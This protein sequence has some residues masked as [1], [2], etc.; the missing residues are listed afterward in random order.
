M[1]KIIISALMATLLLSACSKDPS[2]DPYSTE[3]L[4]WNANDAIT[5]VE[6]DDPSKQ[7]HIE[8]LRVIAEAS[9]REDME[10]YL[11]IAEHLEKGEI[12]KAKKLYKELGGK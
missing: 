8:G 4:L 7:T 10:K 2:K 3:S 9:L 5:R 1:K 6:N 11:K 12:D